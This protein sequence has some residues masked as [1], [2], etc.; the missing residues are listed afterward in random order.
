MIQINCTNCKALLQI[1]DAFA[2]GVCRCRHCGTIQTVPKHLK[3]ANGDGQGVPATAEAIG[4]G[5]AAKTLYQKKK[6]GADQ[7]GAGSGTGL[8][9]LAGIVA[10]SGLASIRLQKKKAEAAAAAGPTAPV[11]PQKNRAL[12]IAGVAGGVIALLIGIIIYMAVR[13]RTGGEITDGTAGGVGGGTGAVQT[14]NASGGG[15]G[16][17]ATTTGGN[18]N[19]QAITPPVVVP[20]KAPPNFLGQALNERS[21]AY[22][23]DRG[24][25]SQ[26]EGRLDLLKQALLRSVQ[27]LGPDRKFAVICWY[28]EGTKPLSYPATGLKAATPENIAELQKFLDDVYA[29]GQTRMSVAMDKAF[30][31]GAEVV[32][33]VP[34]K[35]FL[36]EK[37]HPQVMS[38]RTNA[39]VTTKVHCLTLGQPDIAPQLKK[40]A[41]ETKGAYRDVPMGDLRAAAGQ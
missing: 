13:D 16:D 33:L 10:S 15:S 30:K 12:L 5:K 2:G 17:T 25:A 32:V 8:D 3:N 18:T 31:T 11:D 24:A 35:T 22:V 40:I 29:V 6:G 41:T 36:D 38:L 28:I 39:K 37:F 19:T 14:N 27:T 1:D 7:G 4:S 9:D 26:T 34:I 23:L 21:V 20:K